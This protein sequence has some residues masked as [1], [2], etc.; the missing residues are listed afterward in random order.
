MARQAQQVLN[1]LHSGK[2]VIVFDPKTET[3]N[4]RW[5]S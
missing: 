4:I 5:I 2:A 1:Q 3:C